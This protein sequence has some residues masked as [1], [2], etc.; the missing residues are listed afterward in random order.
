MSFVF[1]FGPS[2]YWF[3][4][5]IDAVFHRFGSS[6]QKYY[7]IERLDPAYRVFAEGEDQDAKVLDVPGTADGLTTWLTD[8]MTNI[9][10][11]S[12]LAERKLG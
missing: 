10:T 8:L 4:D 1:D 7:E 9:G 12:G 5:L 2:W 3:P 6:R 11:T